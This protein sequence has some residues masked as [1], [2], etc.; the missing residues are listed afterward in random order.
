MIKTVEG[1]KSALRNQTQAK[2]DEV[3]ARESTIGLKLNETYAYVCMLYCL[4]NEYYNEPSL[5]MKGSFF[6]TQP[7]IA[8][9]Y[10]KKI[11]IT[12]KKLHEITN[13]S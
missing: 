7:P 13:I 5:S 8:T 6:K 2:M 11:T 3:A 12:Q 10:S 4:Q 1:I 9:K